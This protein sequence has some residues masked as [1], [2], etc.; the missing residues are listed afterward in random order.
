MIIHVATKV[1]TIFLMLA[2][3]AAAKFKRLITDESLDSLCRVVLDVTLPFLFIYVLSTKCNIEAL[4]YMWMAPLFAVLIIL[5]GYATGRLAAAVL[6]V[7]AKKKDTFTFLVSFQNSGFMAIPL[8][9]VLFGQEGVFTVVMFTIG[10]NLLYWTFGV[11]L[12]SR[13]TASGRQSAFRNLVNPS[14]IALASGLILGIFCIRLPEFLLEASHILGNA[15]VPLAMIAVG[16]ILAS[17]KFNKTA[18]FKIVASVVFC[19]LVLVPGAFF[20]LLHYFKDIS[21]LMRSMIMLQACMPSAS[22]G[23]L[24]VKR[25]GGDRDLAANGVFFTTLCSIVT[26]PIFMGLVM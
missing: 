15:T 9:L 24:L 21:G 3:G 17:A 13:S 16:A 1:G 11:W 20:L 10:F 12:L 23:P 2:V 25:F 26:I 6:K 4:S 8:A 14:T 18:D 7:P 22:T 19:R 5:A